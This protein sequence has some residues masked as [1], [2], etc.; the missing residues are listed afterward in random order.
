[1]L[2]IG[3]TGPTGAGKGEVAKLFSEAGLPV[4]NAD[5]VYHRLLIPP[6]PCF[7]ELVAEFGYGILAFDGTLDRKKLSEIVFASHQ[8]LETLNRIAHRH[9]METVRR[10]LERMRRDG[11]RASVLDAP[12]L[13]EAGADR[14][15]SAVV[16]VLADR[17]L[18]M[19]RI[20][21]RDGLDAEAAA[22]RIDA[23]KSDDYFRRNSDYII[24]NNGPVEDLQ[25]QV[26]RVLLDTG[27]IPS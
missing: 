15:C 21:R 8:R 17:N 1:M 10:E 13:F 19:E 12:Q 25:A 4:I 27:V 14:D 16:A 3:L 7:S 2:V 11:V 5:E 23:Q 20:M 22:H 18:R 24:E 6:S 26:T 9:V